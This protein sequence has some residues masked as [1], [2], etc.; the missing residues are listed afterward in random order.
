MGRSIILPAFVQF[1]SEGMYIGR[2]LAGYGELEFELTEC[3]GT[4]LGDMESRFRAMF[5]IKGEQSRLDVADALMRPKF[6]SVGL[7]DGYDAMLEPVRFKWNDNPRCSGS[8]NI[9]WARMSRAARRS[10]AR[11]PPR[12]A[13][14]P[15]AGV[16]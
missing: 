8:S 7:R 3:V 9:L 10:F 6:N 14:R 13:P 15:C 11:P 2:M 5:R 12:Y 16:F 1:P 4:A